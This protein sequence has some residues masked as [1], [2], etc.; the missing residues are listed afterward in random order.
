MSESQSA[1]LGNQILG[2]VLGIVLGSFGTYLNIN[3]QAS[4]ERK[5]QRDQ[6]LMDKRLAALGQFAA[7]L[8]GSG[9]LFEKLSEYETALVVARELPESHRSWQGVLRTSTAF[10]AEYDRWTANLR[11]QA[12]I[13]Q[14][15]FKVPVALPSFPSAED[16]PPPWILSGS[17]TRRRQELIGH[18][19]DAL[20]GAQKL[21]SALLSSVNDHQKE[22]AILAKNL[23]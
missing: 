11:S 15:V 17:K 21:H 23:Y 6:F 20:R 7:A 8:N 22:L 18:T 12:V 14:A 2:I 4:L 19:K 5:Q 13:T 10:L 3:H 9:Q 16:I 1:K